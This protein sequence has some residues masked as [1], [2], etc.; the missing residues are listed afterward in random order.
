M[1][2]VA[3][4]YLKKSFSD[5]QKR[6]NTSKFLLFKMTAIGTIFRLIDRLDVNYQFYYYF[7]SLAWIEKDLGRCN[8]SYFIP[9]V[10]EGALIIS[11]L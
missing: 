2:K 3:V 7:F 5:Y 8:F 11:S 10:V 4:E 6:F 9:I 1:R